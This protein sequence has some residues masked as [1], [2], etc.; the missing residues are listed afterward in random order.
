MPE[1]TVSAGYFEALLEFA[2]ARGADEAEL[3][4][5]AGI[6]RACIGDP[7]NRLAF[8]SYVAL[9]RAAKELTSNS[10][11]PLEFGA[12]SDFRRWSVV[13]LLAHASANMLEA[14]AQLNRYGRLVVEVDGVGDGPRFDNV[15]KDGEPWL[16]DRRTNPNAFPELTE[17]TWSRF[18]C[19]SRASFPH[20]TFALAAHVMHAAPAHRPLYDSLWQVPVTFNSSWN[21]IKVHPAWQTT[22]IDGGNRYAFGVL[23][24][25]GDALL[26]ELEQR[27]TARGGLERLLL[28]RL[29]TGEANIETITAELGVSR[30]TLYRNL[31]DEGVTFERVL[32]ELRHKLALEY[33][34][35]Q[36][37][38]VNE[39]AYLVGFSDPAS[40]SRAFKRWTSKSPREFSALARRVR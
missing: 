6:E 7:D 4:T 3:L 38:S 24:E 39:T 29:H 13:G 14:L 8:T 5:R 34:R 17:S 1:P 16:V 40:F 30:Q 9:M 15:V 11:L 26:H 19:S 25:R 27:R 32:D 18:I 36:Q 23:T 20:A 31:K 33:L 35:G 28:P 22:K 2:I 10:A 37:T 21:A 12:D